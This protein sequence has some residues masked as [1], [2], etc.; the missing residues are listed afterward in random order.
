MQ[1]HSS[2]FK[3]NLSKAFRVLSLLTV[4]RDLK[5]VD[6]VASEQFTTTNEKVA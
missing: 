3:N 1:S 4:A 2:W 6:F 5:Q